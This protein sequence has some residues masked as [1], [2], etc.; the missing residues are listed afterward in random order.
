[1]RLVPARCEACDAFL[2]VDKSLKYA[3]CNYCG[4]QYLVE[5]AIQYYNIT[6]LGNDRPGLSPS[7]E[8]TV[9]MIMKLN[10]AEA[11]LDIGKFDEA[12]RKFRELSEEIPQDYRVWWGLIRSLSRKLWAEV[13][14]R[15]ELEELYGLYDAMM[16]FAPASKRDELDRSFMSY[17]EAQEKLLEQRCRELRSQK[18]RLE[19]EDADLLAQIEECRQKSEQINLKAKQGVLVGF[20]LIIVVGFLLG[21][22]GL[23]ILLLFLFIALVDGLSP[24]FNEHVEKRETEAIEELSGRRMVLRTQ[25]DAIDEQLLQYT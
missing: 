6:I 1:M 19:E 7:A 9:E 11:T 18:E 3:R 12:V 22:P 5:D 16:H 14:G 13:S 20:G 10:S 24:R 4:A 15:A 23:V 25:M 17:A 21:S 8:L 2:E